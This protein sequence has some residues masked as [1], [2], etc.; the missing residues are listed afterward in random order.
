MKPI[1]EQDYPDT[2]PDSAVTMPL[3]GLV[4]VVPL[5]IQPITGPLT[6]AKRANLRRNEIAEFGRKAG[7]Y[8]QLIKDGHFRTDA[9]H[10]VGVTRYTVDAWIERGTTTE[11]NPEPAEPYRSFVD[12]LNALEAMI[13][14]DLKEVV[15][16]AAAGDWKAAKWILTTRWPHEFR[17]DRSEPTN[18]EIGPR[19]IVIEASDADESQLGKTS[20]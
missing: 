2:Q 14:H 20:L 4:K 8:L 18:I 6:A 7:H 17:E 15:R 3:D 11:T 1:D 16:K 13:K 10:I 5:P 19:V 9:A 12:A